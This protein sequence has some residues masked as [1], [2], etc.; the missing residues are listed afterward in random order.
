MHI[1]KNNIFLVGPLGAGKTTVGKMMAEEL[2]MDFFDSDCEIEKRTGVDLAWI[3]DVEGEDSFRVRESQVIDD[4]T[5]SRGIV[6]ATGGGSVIEEANRRCLV[7]RGYVIYLRASV[8]Q[9]LMRTEHESTRRPMLRDKGESKQAVLEAMREEREPFYEEVA[10]TILDMDGVAITSAV[11][12]LV[13][14][15]RAV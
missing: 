14:L 7:A 4:L 5:Q 15:L 8:S 2:G 13:T 6:L 9:Q 12:Q 10:D 11:K 1:E 3:F